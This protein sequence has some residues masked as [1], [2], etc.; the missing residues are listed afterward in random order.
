MAPSNPVQ[1]L[2]KPYGDNM[3]LSN[4]FTSKDIFKIDIF[5]DDRLK[6][7]QFEYSI[8]TLALNISKS[9]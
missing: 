5:V 4:T 8:F 7:I 6:S 9:E 3:Q 1:S 2:Q